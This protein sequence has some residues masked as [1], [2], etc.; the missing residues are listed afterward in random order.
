MVLLAGHERDPF[1][2]WEAG[3]RL[4]GEII[5]DLAGAWQAGQALELDEAFI[6]AYRL[7]LTSDESDRAFLA[8]ALTLPSEKYLAELMPVADPDAIHG[9]RQ[10]VVRTLAS[11]LREDFLLVRERCRRAEPYAVEDGRAGERRLANL[12]L[13]YLMSLAEQPLIELCRDQ[14][15]GSDN[16]TDSIGALTPLVSCD[17]PERREILSTFYDCWQHDRNVIDKWFTLQAMSHLPDTVEEVCRLLE[18]PAFELA[19]PNRFRSLVASFSQNQ[20]RFHA[21]DGSGYRLLTDQLIRLIPI[22]PQVSARLLAPLTTWRRY[23]STRQELMRAE[24]QR[25]QALENLPRD[26]FEVVDKSLREN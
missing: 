2:R 13:A 17:C 23:D 22:N 5:L 18:H 4:A 10:F 24:L 9:A 25:I 1:C 3:Q 8:E 16:M 11:R 21:A 19:N 26:V 20:V 14:Y 15:Y 6:E 12:C 7:T